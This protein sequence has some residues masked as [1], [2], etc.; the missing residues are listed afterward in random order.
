MI[1]F[2]KPDWNNIWHNLLS[3]AIYAIIIALA[4]L[5][6]AVFSSEGLENIHVEYTGVKALFFGSFALMSMTSLITIIIM[7]IFSLLSDTKHIATTNYLLRT[8][9]IVISTLLAFG[10]ILILLYA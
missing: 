10:I 3:S 5:L 4:S 2:N 9:L 1:N 7:L 6:W 8:L